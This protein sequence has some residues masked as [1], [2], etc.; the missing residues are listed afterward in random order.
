MDS[1]LAAAL[2][3]ASVS[4]SAL[5]CSDRATQ[6]GTATD[7]KANGNRM[8][9]AIAI[10]GSSTV[11][12]ISEAV[13][14]EFQKVHE[15][16][17]TVAASGTGGG[18]KKLCAEEIAIAGASRPIKPSEVE[19]C[20][21]RGVNY[22]EL[23]IAYDGIAIVVNP[24]NTWASHMTV[25]ELKKLWGPEAQGRVKTW[26]DVRAGWPDEEIHLFGAGV[27]SGTYDYFT[28][29]IV[30][31]EHTSR[32]DYTSSEDDNVLVKGISTDKLALG[33]FGFAYYEENK[34]ALKLIAID[35]G[36]REN[37]D[38]PIAPSRRTIEDASYQPLSRPVFLYVST[39]AANRPEV[40]AFVRFYLGA[41]TKHVNDVGYIALPAEV[42]RLVKDRFEARTTGSLFA[43]S[44]SQIGV[45][46]ADLLA[47]K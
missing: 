35:D 40:Q 23:P 30:G 22:I 21:G 41:G 36:I 10:D 13:A 15:A 47:G 8:V 26:A 6:V 16:R 29:A 42:Y 9:P 25:E 32:G 46:M 1:K 5:C 39:K 28:K 12:P 14:E 34:G 18:F 11:F 44:G 37:G 27:D 20:K 3:C 2:F 43:G 4:L 38:G 17:V 24:Q 7:S 45:R 19:A 33:F 31:E